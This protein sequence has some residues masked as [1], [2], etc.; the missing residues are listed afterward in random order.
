MEI[1]TKFN[2]GDKVFIMDAETMQP[3]EVEIFGIS[4]FSFPSSTTIRYAA[5]P[6]Q[7]FVLNESECFATREQLLDYIDR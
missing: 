7:G 1:K 5:P 6:E 3:T 2:V 4:V